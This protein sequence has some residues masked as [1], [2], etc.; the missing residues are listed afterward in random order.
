MSS[1][2]L[3]PG[4]VK[5]GGLVLASEKKETVIDVLFLEGNVCE[6]CLAEEGLEEIVEEQLEG[7]G[8]AS[9]THEN[10]CWGVELAINLYAKVRGRIGVFGEMVET[11]RNII[12]ESIAIF[13]RHIRH[14]AGK[15]AEAKLGGLH[16]T[17]DVTTIDNRAGV[18]VGFRHPEPRERDDG[19]RARHVFS[20]GNLEQECALR[21]NEK[22]VAG[23]EVSL[24]LKSRLWRTMELGSD[25]FIHPESLHVCCV[26]RS[27]HQR[28]GV[29]CRRMVP[30]RRGPVLCSLK[31]F[32]VR[33]G[34]ENVVRGPRPVS[35]GSSWRWW[36][37]RR[38][39]AVLIQLNRGQGPLKVV[40]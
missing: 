31:K 27:A 17:V 34:R 25:T 2:E 4:V 39:W 36:S 12:F 37:C 38:L 15:R 5:V 22:G 29:S 7:P 14:K 13:P 32:N 23:A 20:A 1:A 10:A 24:A 30:A 26:G 11:V 16:V 3:N 8:S 35:Q 9:L 40:G 6:L 18:I 28:K 21:R 19:L 33:I